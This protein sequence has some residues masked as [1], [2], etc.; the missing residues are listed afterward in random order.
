VLDRTGII[1][2]IFHRHA[3][4]REA[5]LQVE[6]ARLTYLA[7]RLRETGTSERQRGGIGGKGA[8]ESDVELDKRKVR[9]R[10]AELREELAKI[11]AERGVRRQRRRT[12]RQVAIVGYTNAGKSSLLRALTGAEAFIEDRLFATLDTQTRAWELPGR[13][14]VFLSD[15]VGFLKDLPHHL[16][17]SFR[18]TLAEAL[19]ADLLLHVADAAHP[20]ADVQHEAVDRVL[21]EIG[22]DGIPAILVLNK[23]DA[24]R[25]RI[26]L[27][28]LRKRARDAVVVSARTGEGLADL[29]ARV[30]RAV[31]QDH[32]EVSLEIDA[33]DGRT[34]AW[35]ES[36]A[37]VLARE[38]RDDAVVLRVRMARGDLAR[39]TR[40]ERGRVAAA[41]RRGAR[42]SAR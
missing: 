39:L 30:L 2:E 19:D 33:G 31:E 41:E 37:R 42:N 3:K 36:K 4:S 24:V 23:A 22:A 26:A 5:R 20:D 29:S 1:L 32:E 38:Y 35:I 14:K 34:R 17:A 11:E 18:A 13:R 25:D 21:R 10:M 8:G 40:D 28:V 15:T 7:P 16:V 27:E 9:D 12:E 6:L